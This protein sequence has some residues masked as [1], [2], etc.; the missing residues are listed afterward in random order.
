MFCVGV[1]LVWRGRARGCLREPSLRKAVMGLPSRQAYE[2]RTALCWA[3]W[4]HCLRLVGWGSRL[5]PIHIPR[6]MWCLRFHSRAPRG[7][8]AGVNFW[9]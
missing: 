4:G 5:A 9:A 8:Y 2:A 7:P 1:Q 6:H 3:S